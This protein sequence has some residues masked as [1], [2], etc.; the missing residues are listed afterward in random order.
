M[1]QMRDKNYKSENKIQ[2]NEKFTYL[3]I[4]RTGN[5]GK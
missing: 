3:F 5:E 1:K 4:Q 2:K